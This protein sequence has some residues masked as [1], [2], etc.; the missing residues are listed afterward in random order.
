MSLQAIVLSLVRSYALV[1]GA[2]FWFK[3]LIRIETGHPHKS[4]SQCCK[5]N[6]TQMRILKTVIPSWKHGRFSSLLSTTAR[7]VA[8]ARH[9]QSSSRHNKQGI[10]RSANRAGQ[11]AGPGAVVAS[12]AN[13]LLAL[14]ACKKQH[15][16][17]SVSS[18]P[19]ATYGVVV[20]FSSALVVVVLMTSRAAKKRKRSNKQ[21]NPGKAFRPCDSLQ[22]VMVLQQA[23]SCQGH[24]V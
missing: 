11:A 14:I 10:R 8:V 19:L 16:P 9:R 2:G 6:R 3:R 23:G 12:A 5:D 4:S 18:A 1:R 17:A 22:L 13:Q 7:P 20:M 15:P 21:S 24:D